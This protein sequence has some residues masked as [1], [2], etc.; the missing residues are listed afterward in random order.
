MRII[1]ETTKQKPENITHN[2]A[3]PT[4]RHLHVLGEEKRFSSEITHNDDMQREKFNL[5]NR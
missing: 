4:V 3:S 5:Y 1:P 2:L